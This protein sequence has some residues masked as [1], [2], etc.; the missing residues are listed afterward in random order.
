MAEL[1][2]YLDIDCCEHTRSTDMIMNRYREDSKHVMDLLT[3]NPEQLSKILWTK[4]S[5][6]CID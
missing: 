5:P 3:S 4:C 2:P 6:L 1:S